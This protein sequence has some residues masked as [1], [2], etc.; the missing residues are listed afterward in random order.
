MLHGKFGPL[1]RLEETS[2]ESMWQGI[3]V[4]FKSAA[5]EVMGYIKNMRKEWLDP[6][7]YQL[8]RQEGRNQVTCQP[9][10]DTC[11][12]GD[13]KRNTKHNTNQWKSQRLQNTVVA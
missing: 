7:M 5:E 1:L 8:H 6:L 13:E 12:T 2:S 3:S 4:S 11:N 10:L 9:N